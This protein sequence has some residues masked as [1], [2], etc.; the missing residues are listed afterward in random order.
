MGIKQLKFPKGTNAYQ[1]GK[2][3]KQTIVDFCLGRHTE[4]ELGFEKTRAD[5]YQ[6]WCADRADS[7]V[8]ALYGQKILAG[9]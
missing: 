2:A 6:E 8:I 9:G 5:N 7:Y 4:E 1:K 3:T